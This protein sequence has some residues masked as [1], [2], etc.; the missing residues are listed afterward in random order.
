MH[1]ESERLIIRSFS[2]DD[3]DVAHQILD[4]EQGDST[5]R[6]ER[7]AWIRW[8][9]DSEHH[10]AQLYQPP[11]G[12]RAIICEAV[13]GV[14]GSRTVSGTLLASLRTGSSTGR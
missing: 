8:T 10:L 5:T 12:D 13:A 1:L 2:M 6:A 4:I 9:I 3:L 11:Y 14:F 7:E